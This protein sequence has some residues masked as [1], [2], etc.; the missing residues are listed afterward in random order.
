MKKN[1]SNVSFREKVL[2][3][4]TFFGL[5]I[6][7][8]TELLSF[9]NSINR[10][11]IITLWIFLLLSLIFI[12]YRSLNK[13]RI[14]SPLIKPKI[15][16]NNFYFIFVISLILIPTFIICI[17]YP[18]T[19]PDSMSYHLTRVMNW[20]QNNN[21]NFFATSDTR[22]L[23]M[24]PFSEYF[25]LHLQLIT[26]NDY[27]ANFPQ[28]FSMVFS[29]IGVSLIVKEL[30]GSIRAQLISILFAITLPMG[31][32]QS[33][34]TQTDYILSFWL[35][36]T[37]F[38]IIKLINTQSNKYILGFSLSLALGILTKPTMYL[39]AF[40]FCVW[41]FINF[42]INKKV[43]LKKIILTPLILII[44]IN[45][46][47]FHRTTNL[48]GNPLGIHP[49]I[50]K[51]TNENFSTKYF[52]SNI[53]RNASLNLTFPNKKLNNNLRGLIKLSHDKLNISVDDPANTYGPFYIYFNLYESH[54]PNTLHFIL[55][56]SLLI[57]SFFNRPQSKNFYRFLFAI[58]SGF[59]LQ[60]FILKWQPNANRLILPL[61]ILSSALFAI[62][63]E[64]L[65][66]KFIKN[67]ILLTLFLWSLPYVFFNHTRPLIG[68]ISIKD[69]N[70]EFN[71]PYFLNLNRENLYFIQNLSLYKPYKIV[72]NK[73]QDINC[74]NVSIIGTR[75]DFEYP[76]WVMLDKEVKLQHTNVK[77]VSSILERKTDT[78]N[79]CAIFHFTERKYKS[80]TKREYSGDHQLFSPLHQVHLQE[81][82]MIREKY[83][84]KFE[85][86]I[87]LKGTINGII[88]LY[89]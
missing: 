10:F 7:I 61:F 89:F 17:V 48:F 15:N 65:K 24:P 64:L 11:S 33:T 4:A 79:S 74:S 16:S 36:V 43:S 63:F 8:S 82:K 45:Y 59:L 18:P 77:N 51:L 2:W 83:K 22:Q 53:I 73:L 1:Y 58:I 44:L 6:A 28:W 5:F 87:E 57:I 21:V 88:A 71:K 40:P 68:N 72:I 35:V 32:L 67:L 19:T 3:C 69:T 42:F 37:V 13:K 34:S 38:F 86:E 85:N 31:I 50:T 66:K 81:S 62:S 25:L 78:V 39:F 29:L 27:L 84:K 26:N 14:L 54:A 52:A 30:G 46:G 23:F 75:A 80:F 47:Q 41:L 9:F 60:S 56:I 76:L 20:A 12:F 70:L 49:D 55:I